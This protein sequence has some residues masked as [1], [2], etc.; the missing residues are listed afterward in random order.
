MTKIY[1]VTF[2]TAEEHSLVVGAYS[3]IEKAI[4]D[5]ATWTDGADM[6]YKAPDK[7]AWSRQGNY[8]DDWENVVAQAKVEGAANQHALIYELELDGEE[9]PL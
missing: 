1:V 2:E 6:G 4:E 9:V 7:D 8:V 5:V 3:T